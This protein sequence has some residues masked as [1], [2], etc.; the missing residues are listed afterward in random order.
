MAVSPLPDDGRLLGSSPGDQS[1]RSGEQIVLGGEYDCAMADDL[2]ADLARA[3]SG[4]DAAV[5]VDA[6]AVTFMD[7]SALRV[8]VKT[9]MDLASQGRSFLLRD[10]ASCVKRLLEICKLEEL[11]GC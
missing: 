11:I 9:K 6:S 7:A 10:P 4:H 5:V 1:A 3:A 2:A 8:L